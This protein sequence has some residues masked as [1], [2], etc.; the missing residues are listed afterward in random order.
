[1]LFQV[2]PQAAYQRA[3]YRV[4]DVCL[5]ALEALPQQVLIVGGA[6]QRTLA[7][8]LAFIFPQSK[9]TIVDP[10]AQCLRQA[11]EEICCRFDFVHAPLEALPFADNHFDLTVSLHLAACV[12]HWDLATS[13]LA[14]VTFG[15]WLA[16]AAHASG[17]GWVQAL[18]FLRNAHDAEGLQL[19]A[20]AGEAAASPNDVLRCLWRHGKPV[21]RVALFP[22]TFWMVRMKP[23]REERLRLK[24][25]ISAF[26]VVQGHYIT[27]S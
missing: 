4:L 24:P 5:D 10:D 8:E 25:Q 22:W 1:M 16:S 20:S 14:R 13:E 6:R 2:S 7:R 15:H 3:L 26:C 27:G 18:P 19:S 21:Q 9:M 12:A 23:L 11:K 17:P